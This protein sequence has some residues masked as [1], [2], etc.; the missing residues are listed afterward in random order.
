MA[1]I[2][3]AAALRRVLSSSRAELEFAAKAW[4]GALPVELSLAALGL[5]P[6]LRW[7]EAVSPA[8][9]RPRPSAL[10]V[11]EGERAVGRAY[12]L[13]LLRGQCLPRSLLQYLLH[14]RDGTAVHFIVGVRRSAGSSPG[15]LRSI[16]AHAWV[17]AAGGERPGARAGE[18]FEPILV[19]RTVD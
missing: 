13:H 14:R 16:D 7:I 11:A 15:E 3:P 18:D 8:R 19:S 9:G 2:D 17:E 6:T 12:R 10:S 5:S 4:I 1:R